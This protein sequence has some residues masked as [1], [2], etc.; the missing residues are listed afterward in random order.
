MGILLGV[1]A[2]TMA[3]GLY[4]L[5]IGLQL[6]PIHD[7]S[8]DTENPPRFAAVLALRGPNAN[9]A[10]YAGAAIAEQQHRAYP[11]IKPVLLALSRDQ[12]FERALAAAQQIGWEIVDANAAE[13]RIEAVARTFWL[14]FKDDVVVRVTEA[15][16]GSRVD[17]RSASRIGRHDFGANARRLTAYLDRL[18]AVR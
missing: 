4:W 13:G 17:A 12:A 14:R 11:Q 5:Y 3:L 7:I 10:E 8:T 6:P 2:V 15:P 1:L 9:P 18:K 16:G